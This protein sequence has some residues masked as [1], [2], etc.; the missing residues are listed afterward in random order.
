MPAKG[1]KCLEVFERLMAAVAKV[2]GFAR[3]RSELTLKLG[4]N[5]IAEGARERLFRATNRYQFRRRAALGRRDAILAKL[6]LRLF[7][8]PIGSPCRGKDGYHSGIG[9]AFVSQQGDNIFFH[10]L[11]RRT[12]RIGRSDFDLDVLPAHGNIPNDAQVDDT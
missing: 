11:E 10:Q 8:H 3:G 9:K 5:R 2:Q 1:L 7:A 4:V 12:A 6:R